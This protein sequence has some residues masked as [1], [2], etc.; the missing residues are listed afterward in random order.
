MGGNL[1]EL[2]VKL[3]TQ[4]YKVLFIIIHSKFNQTMSSDLFEGIFSGYS[5]Q[6]LP[7]VFGL[8]LVE[9]VYRELLTTKSE[10]IS[11]TSW[12]IK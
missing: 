2:A 8:I 12:S 6:F 9:C 7:F 11:K 1:Y 10:I 4:K 3:L 5:L